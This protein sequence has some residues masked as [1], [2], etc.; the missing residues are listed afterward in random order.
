MK[1]SLRSAAL[2]LLLAAGG[3]GPPSLG[4]GGGPG[5]GDRAAPA[6][7]D[8]ATLARLEA[9]ARALA[10]PSRCGEGGA[11]AT[12]PVGSR[13]C[14][15]PREYVVYCPVTT[16]SAALY[17]ALEALARAEEA[18]NREHELVSTCEFRMPP[19]TVV[20]NG[21]C[22]AVAAGVEAAPM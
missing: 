4:E 5:G 14:G 22:R 18:Y 15:G 19:A 20:E 1:G 6:A 10:D 7:P 13:P 9:E 12:A 11:C 2:V 17:G 21:V 8:E 3:C 16:D